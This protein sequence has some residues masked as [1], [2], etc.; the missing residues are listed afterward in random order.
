MPRRA[1]PVT[2]SGPCVVVLFVIALLGLYMVNSQLSLVDGIPQ[3]GFSTARAFEIWNATSGT[4]EK[5]GLQKGTGKFNF[6]QNRSASFPAENHPIAGPDIDDPA[7]TLAATIAPLLPDDNGLIH[8]CLST[9]SVDF[10]GLFVA[11][12][13]TLRHASNPDRIK[14]H[15]ITS[16]SL[17]PIM[18]SRLGIYLHAVNIDIRFNEA[19]Q[20][21]I[22]KSIRYENHSWIHRREQELWNPFNFVPFFLPEFLESVDDSVDGGIR[23]DKFELKRIVYLDTDVAVVSDICDLY[24]IDLRGHPVAAGEDCNWRYTEILGRHLVQRLGRN[25]ESCDVR[26]GAMVIDVAQWKANNISQRVEEWTMFWRNSTGRMLWRPGAAPTPWLLAIE[27]NFVKLDPEW[28]CSNLGR[29]FMSFEEGAHVRHGGFD[30]KALWNL[31]I[32]FNSSTGLMS[33]YLV[34]C[35]ERAKLLHFNGPLKPWHP[36]LGRKAEMAGVTAENASFQLQFPACAV[37]PNKIRPRVDWNA[38]IVVQVGR[39]KFRHKHFVLC[40]ALWSRHIDDKVNCALKDVGLDWADEEAE[41]AKKY[42][43]STAKKAEQ[44]KKDEEEEEK[45]KEKQANVQT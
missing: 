41:W 42:R 43:V 8:V 3:H 28:H 34:L 33:T 20:A 9:N 17:A 7:V 6:R 29:S 23:G 18:R 4:L 35:S 14:F 38:T 24:R 11:I 22:E 15:V 1:R 37:P 19:V 5:F 45:E 13:S 30:S 10:R 32:K 39:S 12:N 44:K 36:N 31:G 26:R 2:I 27:G 16:A 21:R 25:E 40:R